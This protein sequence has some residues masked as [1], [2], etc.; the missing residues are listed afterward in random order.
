MKL[1]YDSK[2]ISFKEYNIAQG[3]AV[4]KKMYIKN[5]N[6][7]IKSFIGR[8]FEYGLT[9][10][11]CFIVLDILAYRLENIFIWKVAKLS[12]VL[13]FLSIILPLFSISFAYFKFTRNNYSKGMIIIDNDGITDDTKD[14]LVIS[15][16]WEGINLLI[17]YRSL[18]IVVG[19]TPLF[20]LVKLENEEKVKKEILKYCDEEKCKFYL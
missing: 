3:I 9:F 16:K 17:I 10:I 18:L 20:L 13:G 19:N 5:K 8:L 4:F 2:N 14:N 12:L 7:K 6:S 11:I 1:K 15:F